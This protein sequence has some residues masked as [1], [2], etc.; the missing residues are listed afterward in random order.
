MIDQPVMTAASYETA[1]VEATLQ[2]ILASGLFLFASFRSLSD[3]GGEFDA[4]LP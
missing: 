4:N 1:L 3:S 2:L